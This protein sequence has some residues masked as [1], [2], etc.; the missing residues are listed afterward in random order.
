MQPYLRFGTG[1]FGTNKTVI[2][3]VDHNGKHD[4]NKPGESMAPPK[5][6]IK[7]NSLTKRFDGRTGVDSLSLTVHEGELYALLGENGAGKTTTMR[8][9]TGLMKPT[10]GTFSICG[11]EGGRQIEK[12]KGCIGLVSQ[13]IALYNELTVRENLAFT[14]N[15]YGVP[16][17]M[18]EERIDALL[19][20]TDLFERKNSR[21]GELSSGMKMKLSI[22]TAL[23]HQPRVLFMD[24]PTLGLDPLSRRHIWELLRQLVDKGLTILLT[25]HYLEEA[26]LLADR[27]G[28][29]HEGKMLMEG[30]IDE[31]R[32]HV[33]AVRTIEVSLQSAVSI[34]ERKRILERFPSD[35]KAKIEYDELSKTVIFTPPCQTSLTD[36]LQ[37]VLNWLKQEKIAFDTFCTKEPSLEEIFLSVQ[38]NS[39]QFEREKS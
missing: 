21:A 13:E 16:R 20:H 24:E 38:Q 2:T 29:I 36:Y 33:R 30:A 14:G 15:L 22:A 28:I 4:L 25:T 5:P 27:I 39:A 31:L 32:T 8:M 1:T 18:C 10:A 34:E 19:Q 3:S 7:C 9:L 17:A 11:Y 37:V 23:I 12:I 35:K 6:T 26:Q